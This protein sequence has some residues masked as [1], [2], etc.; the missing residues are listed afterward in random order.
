MYGVFTLRSVKS[1][2]ASIEASVSGVMF[3]QWPPFAWTAVPCGPPDVAAPPVPGCPE[4]MAQPATTAMSA[5]ASADPS[6]THG[7]VVPDPAEL[8]FA[9]PDR[10][11]EPP[12]RG[13]I[14]VAWRRLRLLAIVMISLE[15]MGSRSDGQ[16][17]AAAAV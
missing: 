17:A 3:V 7:R 10:P 9:V 5:T 16:P 1:F 2:F 12:A 6:S 4:R 15:G 13:A 11:V 8:R 14:A